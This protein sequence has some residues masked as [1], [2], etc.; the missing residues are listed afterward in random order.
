MV[1]TRLNECE[2][3]DNYVDT[4]VSTALKLR[5]VGMEVSAEWIGALLLAGLPEEYAPMIMGIESSGMNISSDAIKTKLLQDVKSESNESALLSKSR[6]FKNKIKCFK[7]DK[8][9]HI[10]KNCRAK[11]NYKEKG[12]KFQ[13]KFNREENALFTSFVAKDSFDSNDWFIDSGASAHMTKRNDLISTFYSSNNEVTV[14]NNNRLKVKGTGDVRMN[15]R[16]NDS[17]DSVLIKNVQYV[18]GICANLLSVSRM[19]S[20]GNEV[21][22]NS[23]GCFIYNMENELI[24]KGSL[25]NGMYRLDCET[26]K[27]MAVIENTKQKEILWHRRFGHA[28]FDRLRKLNDNKTFNIKFSTKT[29]PCEICVKGKQ[30]R[31]T[32][33]VQE[34]KNCSNWYT[35]TCVVQ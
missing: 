28:S 20:E 10:A 21:I 8:L 23:N 30:T 26:D 12:S 24:A 19:C 17:T 15:V 13:N 2:N 4:I 6:K 27:C 29:E 18:P 9:G 33:L 1:T 3:V 35:R 31:L 16:K 25:N 7:C 11:I 5:N 32:A 22:F 14:A 34:Q